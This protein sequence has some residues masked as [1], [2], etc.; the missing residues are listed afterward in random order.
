MWRHVP[1]IPALKR[2]RQVDLCELEASW[3][4]IARPGQSK[5]YS[6]ILSQT[7]TNNKTT[8]KTPLPPKKPKIPP[9]KGICRL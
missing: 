9:R 6:E 8:K 3:V 2:Q 7:T 5:L 4:Y 1:L